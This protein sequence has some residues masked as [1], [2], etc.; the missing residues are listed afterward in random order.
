M[1]RIELLR[2]NENHAYGR[3]VSEFIHLKPR[4]PEKASRGSLTLHRSRGSFPTQ[5]TT[6]FSKI[7][8]LKRSL[9]N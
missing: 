8:F 9:Q 7:L 3:E 4:N 6:F 1:R 2:Y 5:V